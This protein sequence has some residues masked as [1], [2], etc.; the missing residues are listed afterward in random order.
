[1]S[2]SIRRPFLAPIVGI[3][4]GILLV[5]PR[6]LPAGSTQSVTT[7]GVTTNVYMPQGNTA[8]TANGD[9]VSDT[10]GFPAGANSFY[11]YFIEVPA[12]TTR[13]TVD[14]FDP[15]VGLG[16]ATE[17]TAGRDR[18][19]NADFESVA[20]YTLLNPAGVAQTTLFGTGS[21]T[22]PALSDNAWMTFFSLTANTVRDNFGTS[23]FTNNDGNNNWS[24]AWV[25]T[26]SGG[27]GAGAGAVRVTGGE[28]RM[29]DGVSGSPSLEREA[30]LLGTPGLNLTTAFLTFDFRTSNTLENADQISVA[31]SNNGGGSYT[32]LET[33]SDD[34]SGSRSYNISA[35]IANNTRVRFQMAGGYT[36]ADEFFYVDNVQITD[37]TATPGHWELQVDMGAG[38]DI[39]A[40][41]IRAHDGTSG[42]GGTELN[43]Y[44]DSFTQFGV[45]PPASGTSTRVYDVFPYVTAGCTAYENDF[46]YDS[47]RGN[48]G[49]MSFNSRTG[50]VTPPSLASTS[51]TGDNVWIRNSLSGW[52]SDVSSTGYGIWSA[53][54]S[55]SSYA[56]GGTPN[57]NY[58]TFYMSSPLAADPVVDDPDDNPEPGSFRTYLPSDANAAPVKPYLEQLLT[59]DSGPN[60]PQV[61]QRTDITVTVRLV[62][63]TPYQ[64]TFPGSNRVTANV[65]ATAGV[66][67]DDA[68]QVSQGSITSEPT[69]G[70]TG[71]VVWNPGPVAAG[72]TALMSYEVRVTPTS[73]GQRLVVTGLGSSAS[74]GTR[75]SFVDETGNSTQTRATYTLGP[76]CELAITQG[77][78][79]HAVV[80]SF[81]TFADE[82]GGVRVEWTT[83]SENGTAGFRLLRRNADGTFRPVHEELLP[84]LIHEAQGGTYRFLDESASSGQSQAYLLEEVEAN[85]RRRTYGPYT[86]LPSWERPEG[87]AARTAYE[88]EAHPAL[89]K[90][91]A[92]TVPTGI[93]SVRGSMQTVASAHL[94][95]RETGLYYVTREQVATWL[96]LTVDKAEKA[97]VKEKL[98]LSR[99]GLPAAWW[100]DTADKKTANGLFFYGEA[101]PSLYSLDTVYR[102]REGSGPVMLAG[103]VAP[104]A[105]AAGGSFP[106]SKP[107]ERDL[108]PA[109]AI[110]PDPESDYWFWDF[111]ISGDPDLGKRTFSF[112]A[113]ALAPGNGTITVTLQGATDN[114]TPGEHRAAVRVNGTL[115]GEAQW[116]GIAPIVQTFPVPDGVLLEM[117]N[118]LE[119]LGTVGGGA[120][121]SFYFVDGFEVGYPRRFAAEGN[122]LAFTS[123]GS[124]SVTVSGFS[125]PAVRLVDVSNPLRP[126]WLTGAA[127]NADGRAWRASF[128][129]SASIR[130]FAAGQ[131]ALKTPT[132]VRPWSEADLLSSSN[133]ADVLIVVP[134]GMEAEAERLAD[135]RRSQGLQALVAS[136]DAVGD[137]F[138]NGIATPHALRGLLATARTS[139]SVQPSYVV[140]VGEG[141]LD[142]RNLQGFGDS[143][144]P[145]LMVQAEGGL[146]PSDNRLADV[147]EDGRP[148]MAIGRIPVLTAAELGA[149]VDKI[150][151]YENAGS[152]A[153]AAN[154]LMLADNIDGGASFAQQS[155]GIAA[156]LPAGFAVDRI[157]LDTEPL[158]QARTRLLQGIGTGASL[159]DY[160]GHGG[161]DRLSAGGLLT[162]EDVP[163]LTN[164]ERLPVVTAMTCTVNRF[165]VPGVP[166]LGE[167][168]VK[169]PD[170][171]AA[172]VW[173]PSGLS[174]H[175]EARHL[176]EIFY[177]RASDPAGG[178]LGDWILQ[179]MKDFGAMGGDQGML[180]IYNLL[181][182][183]TLIVR[184]GPA[185][186][187]ADGSSGE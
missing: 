23:A 96:G 129:P 186:A 16:G 173:G 90:A 28:L 48:T 142:Y 27:A 91:H 110:S 108:F 69:P 80:S 29:Q 154:A 157:Y 36:D 151:A 169:S 178:R 167:L 22:L 126:R 45:N 55:I 87:P 24:A 168:L 147:D 148:D 152:P 143:V 150:L 34:S 140:L 98:Y 135:F 170:G 175:G 1:M 37:G 156:Q 131:G 9:F 21:A 138:G 41:G 101:Q 99:N 113:P 105:A 68:S 187:P 184:R 67:Y 95:I 132:A 93:K 171:G 14:L 84:G 89:R 128:V 179:S 7:S 124:S 172:A 139:W 65:P 112:D 51:L 158:A 66:S 42:A 177:R 78:L 176:A 40:I 81:R 88:R 162:S 121:F 44:F 130:Y 13:L 49:S 33:F 149:Y 92:P 2:L 183:P 30:D 50:T 70:S 118:Q 12:G 35:Y 146:F 136:L 160:V 86:G 38:D 161:L 127:V 3:A 11:R 17:D 20:T 133:Q 25:E 141:T 123:G 39:N 180:D 166:S 58:T 62:N 19:R 10:A 71:D 102:L 4:V 31:V 59:V 26:D 111:V 174:S 116:Q 117:G 163:G 94:S 104:A 185:P 165:A 64:I 137:L 63:P 72:A 115:L 119:I 114:A 134:P 57:G 32:T 159:I 106:A 54:V 97:I 61:G 18:T 153:W 74:T 83:A 120:P 77:L 60:P 56:V 15:D 76:I 47:N 43:V 155:D 85:G 52:T 109:T 73:G 181:G 144:M 122:A 5:I 46:D 182:D 6:L 103:T 75:A 164:G 79:T 107:F 8:G 82:R 145:P 125:N 100:P 53:D